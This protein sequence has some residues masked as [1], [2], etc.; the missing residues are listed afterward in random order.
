MALA[1]MPEEMDGKNLVRDSSTFTKCLQNGCACA[2]SNVQFANYVFRGCCRLHN[3]INQIS[4][5]NELLSFLCFLRSLT[6]LS[7]VSTSTNEDKNRLCKRLHIWLILL[8]R[9]KFYLIAGLQRLDQNEDIHVANLSRM[10]FNYILALLPCPY[11][12]PDIENCCLK[13]CQKISQHLVQLKSPSKSILS[14]NSVKY[15][16]TDIEQSLSNVKKGVQMEC[17]T[18]KVFTESSNHIKNYNKI[19]LQNLKINWKTWVDLT[20]TTN[21]SNTLFK[22]PILTLWRTLVDVKSNMTLQQAREFVSSVKSLVNV[23]SSERDAIIK[24]KW[25]EIICEVLCY[26]STLGIQSDVPTEASELAHRLIRQSKT[27]SFEAFHVP[28]VYLGL[29]GKNLAIKINFI[30]LYGLEIVEFLYT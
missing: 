25:L 29:A 10:T 8:R 26:G 24:R 20:L 2:I 23:L 22:L 17:K 13:F 1:S 16:I 6:K 28:Q 7:M 11:V 5:R 3:G 9:I 27:E 15:T 12:H 14:S 19:L 21:D 4:E 18:S 30:D